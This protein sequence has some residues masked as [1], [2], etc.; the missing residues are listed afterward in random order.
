MKRASK[1]S[2]TPDKKTFNISLDMDIINK[3]L[4]LHGIIVEQEVAIGYIVST[5]PV[6]NKGLSFIQS[7]AI[8]CGCS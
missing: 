3:S 5:S 4:Q 7:S 1:E 6:S 2:G 8:I